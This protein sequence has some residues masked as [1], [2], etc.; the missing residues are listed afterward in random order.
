MHQEAIIS[1]KKG[2]KMPSGVINKT[3][4]SDLEI[5]T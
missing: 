2:K 5:N 3:P 4:V 1:Q